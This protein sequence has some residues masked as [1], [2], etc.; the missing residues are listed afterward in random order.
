MY[1]PYFRGKQFELIAIRESASLIASAS[2]VP[3]IEPV[4]ESLGGLERTLRSLTDAGAQAIVVVNPRHGDHRGNGDSIST[5]LERDYR[6]IDAVSA[7]ILLRNDT[8][9]D[10]AATLLSAHAE[11]N[12]AV[13]HAGFTEARTVAGSLDSRMSNV[14]NVFI[15]DQTNMLYRRHFIGSTRI[16]IRDGFERK[17]NA[18]YHE[19]DNFSDLHI[20]YRDMGMDGYGDFLTVGDNYSEGGGPAYAVAI[21]LTYIDPNHDQAMFIYHF[22]SDTND[23]PTDPAGKFA[24]A[25]AKL[26]WRLDKGDSKLVETSAI[27]EFRDLHTRGHFPG[28]GYVKKLS[29][30]HHLETLAN[31][32]NLEANA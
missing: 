24:Q 8:S 19:V 13:V 18:D 22:V 32:H 25:L 10:E 16:L 30:K 3:I 15:E 6:G 7:G 31:Y 11:Q 1:Y 20:T 5:L 12:T 14:R 9:S 2:F 21:H 27:R 23:T 4:R 29:I 28:L 26:I 17:R